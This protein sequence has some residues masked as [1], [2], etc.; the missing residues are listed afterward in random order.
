MS[1]VNSLAY[2][3]NKENHHPDLEIGYN[4][5]HI[6]LTTH[7]I[8]GLSVNDFIVAAKIDAVESL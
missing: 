7:A 3:A 4:Y 6:H 2:I 1:F 5:C 8:Q